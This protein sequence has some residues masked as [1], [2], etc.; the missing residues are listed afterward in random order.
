VRDNCQLP[1]LRCASLYVCVPTA[2]M[3]SRLC[4][5][6][7]SKGRSAIHYIQRE[8]YEF[9]GM[10]DKDILIAPED[11]DKLTV[12]K[13]VALPALYSQTC[14]VPAG[15]ARIQPVALSRMPAGDI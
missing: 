3:E 8:L 6:F 14:C 7:R 10:D 2:I 13:Y 5:L 11:G 9:S 12:L 15:M 4:I 1:Y